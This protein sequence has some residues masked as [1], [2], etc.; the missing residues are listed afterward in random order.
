VQGVQGDVGAA[1]AVGASGVQGV[2]GADGASGPT[3]AEGVQGVQGDVGAVGSRGPTGGEGVTGTAGS[4]GAPGPQGAAGPTGAA[5]A[6]GDDGASGPAGLRGAT[7]ATGPSGTN[8]LAE[9]GYVYNLTAQTVAIEADIPFDSNG[10]MTAGIIHAPGSSQITLVNAGTYKVSFSVSGTEPNQMAV[11]INGDVVAGSTYGSG[12]GTQQNTGQATVVVADG[13][14]LTIR[15]HS[16]SAAVGLAS[17]IG[18]TQANVN[19][20]VSIERVR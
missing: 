16:S 11:F 7:G 1:G 15:N 17:V 3:G 9:V 20:S 5:G 18:G 4:T 2:A 8:G 10:P 12:A 19:A 14:V 6:R 13:D